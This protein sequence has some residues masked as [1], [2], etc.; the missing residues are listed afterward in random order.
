MNRFWHRHF[1]IFADFSF[2]PI[3]FLYITEPVFLPFLKASSA[4]KWKKTKMYKSEYRTGNITQWFCRAVK[5]S[6]LSV[7]IYVAIMIYVI[8]CNYRPGD[9]FFA[10]QVIRNE[11][12]FKVGLTPNPKL[13]PCP[14]F[15]CCPNLPRQHINLK[16]TYFRASF[17]SNCTV[18]ET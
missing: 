11:Q 18:F 14:I 17:W 1:D 2:L 6:I 4:Q 5:L 15:I 9:V 7:K 13:N 10:I 12:F 16:R 3:Q 8:I